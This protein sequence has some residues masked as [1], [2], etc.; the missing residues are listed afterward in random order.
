MKREITM[1]KEST[2]GGEEMKSHYDFSRGVRGRH[3]RANRA[4]HSV[5]INKTDGTV[6]AHHFT[7][8][9]GAVM[10]DPDLR[11]RF[12]DSQS[13]NSALRELTAHG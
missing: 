2:D 8:Q 3:F 5:L 9:D 10:L 12:P 7:L 11:T 1:T 4:G 13:V 6:E